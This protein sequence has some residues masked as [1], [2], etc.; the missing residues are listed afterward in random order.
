MSSVGL[1]GK[2]IVGAFC[3]VGSMIRQELSPFVSHKSHNPCGKL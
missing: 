2:A 3:K 1:W